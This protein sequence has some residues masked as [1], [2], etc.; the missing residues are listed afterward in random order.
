M[1]DEIT[2]GD[3]VVH[4]VRG[5]VIEGHQGSSLLGMTYLNRFA[6]VSFGNGKM[7]LTR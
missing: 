7:V 6:E 1:I 4:N 2:I 3:I 5:V